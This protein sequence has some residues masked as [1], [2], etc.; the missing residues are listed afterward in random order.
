MA[1]H[2]LLAD[3]LARCALRDRRAF[4]TLYQQTSPILYGLLLKLT[5]DR[6]SAADLLQEGFVRIWQRAGDYRPQL[7]QPITWMGSIVR[8]LSIDRLRR[9]E[10]RHRIELDD[11]AWL[12][13]ADA[14]LSP[15][16]EAHV[17]QGDSA[18]ARCLE[19]LEPEPRRAVLLAY[20]EGLTHD[21]IARSLD[22]PLGTVKAWVRRSLQRLKTCLGEAS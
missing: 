12:R 16:E 8:H 14:G 9:G 3:L 5:R 13:V 11:E 10:H 15:E 21:A 7:G 22:R 17:Q 6:D 4:E 20:F 2:D 19:A 1:S 18:L